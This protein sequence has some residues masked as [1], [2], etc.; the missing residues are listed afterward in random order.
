MF[1][2]S[3]SPVVNRLNATE[4]SLRTI[5]PLRRTVHRPRPP[6]LLAALVVLSL[7]C[8]C[9]WAAPEMSIGFPFGPGI[10]SGTASLSATTSSSSL[11]PDPNL[12]AAIREALGKPTG[13]IT[14][15]D[16]QE[17]TVLW[18]ENSGVSDLTGLELCTNLNKLWV[19]RNGVSDLSPLSRL[20]NLTVLDIGQCGVRDLSP[21]A[22]VRSL[23]VLYM[24]RNGAITDL[25]PLRRLPSLR[26]LW[27]YSLSMTTLEPLSDLTTLTAL[28]VHHSRQVTSLEPLRGLT[29]LRE[30]SCHDTACPT[31]APDVVWMDP[32]SD[33]VNLESL[34]LD[35]TS[36]STLEPI[37]G[38][39]KL[40]YLWVTKNPLTT[41]E[42][43]RQM[44]DLEELYVHECKSLTDI[45]ALSDLPNLTLIEMGGTAV[46]SI[47]PLS[48]CANLQ[49][50]SAGGNQL[51]DLSPLTGLIYLKRLYLSQNHIS[52]LTPLRALTRLTHL[53]LN[54]NQIT[55]IAPLVQNGGLGAYSKVDVSYNCLD[56][57]PGSSALADI[58]ALLA[59]G[60]QLTWRPQAL[61][62][63]SPPT[64]SPNPVRSG[65]QVACS[66]MATDTRGYQ[67]TYQWSATDEQDRPAGS[68]ED[69]TG[70]QTTWTA[71][72]NFTSRSI[73]CTVEVTATSEDGTSL[74]ASYV[75]TVDPVLRLL[76]AEHIDSTHVALRFNVPVSQEGAETA[77]SYS[78]SG[79]LTV[80]S[81]ALDSDGTTVTLQTSP[82][83]ENTDYTVTVSGVRDAYGV[84]IAAPYNTA[85]WSAPGVPPRVLSA[86][87]TDWTKVAVTFDEQLQP[88][89]AERAEN[90]SI[91][92]ALDVTAA[93]LDETGR[94]V[95]LTTERQQE[96]TRYTV[97]V[98]NVTDLP[99]NPVDPE[100]N[101]AAWTTPGIPP[102]V[103]E[104]SQVSWTKLRVAFS[105]PVEAASAE[106]IGNYSIDPALVVTAA[107]LS[108]RGDRVTLTTALH[109][110]STS[111][112]VTV[113]NVTDIA[114]N[115]VDPEHNSASFTTGVF[116]P[117][118]AVA[119]P[120]G[121]AVPR[122]AP[123]VITF[124]KPMAPA[125]TREAF[126]IEPVAGGSFSWS[127]GDRV[128]TFVPDEPLAYQTTYTVRIGT[129]AADAAGNRIEEEHRWSFTTEAWPVFSHEFPAGVWMIGVPVRLANPRADTALNSPHAVRWDAAR[130]RYHRFSEGAFDVAP[131]A[132]YWVRYAAARQLGLMGE[133]QPLPL[134]VQL[135]AGWN[136]LSNPGTEPLR[137]D[138]V[139]A[140]GSVKPFG[141]V[142]SGDGGGYE[143][144]AR[145][146]GLNTRGEI[147]PWQ[148]F[149]LRADEECAVTLGGQSPANS[150]TES[151][152]T[153]RWA[154][155]LHASAGGLRDADNYVGAM[156]SASS[157]LSAP[158]PPR[159]PGD[160]V[161]LYVLDQ[162]GE[163]SAVS[164][165]ADGAST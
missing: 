155:R 77:D 79:E 4:L 27:A 51:S 125:P 54:H 8:S 81:A 16:L 93:Q 45:D 82:Q 80:L 72:R 5:P 138:A 84:A 107:T 42:P 101:T 152:E 66:A 141:W 31:V 146:P 110:D 92:P 44:A 35:Y 64:G 98:A 6:A 19:R 2:E 32:L 142:Q 148:G 61:S 37:A 47:A 109:A 60:T 117:G 95:T 17:V 55:D 118:V 75:H 158:N 103:T 121:D 122:T 162:G 53:Y 150:P 132:G 28:R 135:S 163:H 137:W 78:V 40:K 20:Q 22:N 153:A 119:E 1:S 67:I 99:G 33:L 160:F 76:R 111:Y 59:R 97:T 73:A 161:D 39:T 62:F 140:D 52:D 136:L 105:E 65:R 30:L 90:F 7:A 43:L 151:H 139:C 70:A 88:A 87:R 128:L 104:A 143:L 25:E 106:T 129:G 38:L 29:N 57:S 50:L 157:E 130:Q 74:S 165:R 96:N 100:H 24:D 63:S 10:L 134:T 36:V 56:L 13:E 120:V 71:P 102:R 91:E 49:W 48:S 41:L 86:T 3:S 156:A 115:T 124:S 26:V 144:V 147:G 89:A 68:F 23:E 108:S 133:A 21:L 164:L 14:E 159:Y 15:A 114:G 34:R 126:S 94:I 149:W 46:R 85:S 83:P 154:V 123:V 9:A 18:A 113:A 131:G 145:L 12:L 127:D 11:I 69:V 116:P 112:T 58:E